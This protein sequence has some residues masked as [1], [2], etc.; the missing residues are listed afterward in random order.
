QRIL[1]E[2]EHRRGLVLGL[3]L[4]EILILLLF[5]LLLALGTRLE[6]MGRELGQALSERDQY[7]NGPDRHRTLAEQTAKENAHLKEQN[8]KLK[9]E[10]EEFRPVLDA[11]RKIDPNEPPAALL[12][13]IERVVSVLRPEELKTVS[14]MSAGD[15]LT[16]IIARS[17]KLGNEGKP[18]TK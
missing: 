4:A 13:R 5:L 17:G 8:E 6:K 15:T 18:S 9:K 2:R 7:K 1:D 16:V 3:T 14:Q 12:K 10:M 11:A